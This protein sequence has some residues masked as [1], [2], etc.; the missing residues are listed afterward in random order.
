[1]HS[2]VVP[3]CRRGYIAARLFFRF[4]YI[5]SRDYVAETSEDFCDGAFVRL[6]AA[7]AAE[8][9]AAAAGPL[10]NGTS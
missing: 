6:L 1:M 5:C 4:F 3:V 10:M 8:A 2:N 9:A 7:A